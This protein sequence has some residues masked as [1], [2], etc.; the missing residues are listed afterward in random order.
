M[1]FPSQRYYSHKTVG[2]ETNQDNAAELGRL[3]NLFE[4]SVQSVT[5]FLA[6]LFC[7]LEVGSQD[8]PIF[9]SLPKGLK[10]FWL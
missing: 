7:F 1:S 3:P 9:P 6:H 10:K 4:N 5:D 8:P 2:T